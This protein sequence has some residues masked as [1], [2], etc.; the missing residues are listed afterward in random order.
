[1]NRRTMLKST[2]AIS[3]LGGTIRPVFAQPA[4][5][6]AQVLDSQMAYVD[7][8]SG[9]PVVFLHGNPT[10]SYLWRNI[11]PH[12]SD[13]HRAIAPDLIGMGDSGKP[14]ISFTYADHEAYLFALLDSLDLQDAVL[15]IHDWGSALGFHYARTRPERVS[16][17]AFMEAITAPVMPFASYEVMGDLGQMF[18]AWRTEGVGEQMILQDN[19]FIDQILGQMMVSTP[20]SAD[21]LAEYN[22][23]Y[24]TPESRAP[25]LEWPR[26]V[27]IGGV[28]DYSTSVIEANNAWLTESDIPKLLLHVTP[29]A[30]IPPPAVEWLSANVPNL[31]TVDLGEGLHFIQEDHPEAIGSA[32]SDWLTRI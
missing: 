5:E 29:G 7:V 12:V 10:S 17:V 24:P 26:Q 20:L 18:E 2:A 1:M 28:P 11:I 27:P 23:Y 22:R 25:I 8:G 13:T 14:D 21:V 6:T 4:K 19:M 15:V 30:I 32:I 3:M 31:E 9:R 16:A